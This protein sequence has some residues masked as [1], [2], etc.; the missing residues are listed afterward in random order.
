MYHRVATLSHD[1]WEL[2]VSPQHFEEQIAYVR[3]YRSPMSMEDLVGKLRS[4]T[5]PHNAVAIT[6]DDGYRDNLVNAAP[7][8]W[9]HQVPATFFIATGYTQRQEAF[10]W[11]ELAAMILESRISAH[12]KQKIADEV[13][14]FEWRDLENADLSTTWRGWDEPLTARQKA[15]VDTW[16]RLQKTTQQM[17]DQTMA[18]LRN[19]F[20]VT[21]DPLALPMSAAELQK[22]NADEVL[23]LE[24]HTVLHPSLTD[25]N[26][27]ESRLEMSICKRECEALAASSVNGFA[28]PYGNIS[29]E[30]CDDAAIAGYAWACSTESNFLDGECNMLALP[31]IA[32][33]NVGATTFANLLMG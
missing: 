26:R 18:A 11:D 9:H 12:H 14:L 20:P 22:L 2:A 28:Y 33:A 17:R 3:Q 19:V 24:A 31:R 8:L 16:R 13:C 6:F 15:Y 7:V 1:P 29:P 30:V 32:A 23:T 4:R 27:D 10:W 5:L 21:S 25:L